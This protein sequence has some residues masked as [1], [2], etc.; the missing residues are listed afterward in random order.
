MNSSVEKNNFLGQSGFVWWMGV[1]ENRKDP[2]N[3]GRCKIRIFGWHTDDLTLIPTDDLPWAQPVLPPNNATTFTTPKEGDYVVGF[4]FDGPSGQA[5]AYFG[6]IPGVPG[7]T[8]FTG[9]DTPQKGFQDTRSSGELLT[10]PSLP[11]NVN[12]QNDGS[13]TVTNSKPASRNPETAGFSTVNKLAVNN[14]SNPPEA[15]VQRFLETTKGIT[16]PE[17]RSLTTQVAGAAQGAA[18]TLQ[19]VPPKLEALVPTAQQLAKDIQP[20]ASDAAKTAQNLLGKVQ[21]ST[22]PLL[23]T[24]QETGDSIASKL[25]S[26]GDLSGNPQS[27]IST[28]L[29]EVKAVSGKLAEQGAAAK[30]AVSAQVAEAQVEFEAAAAKAKASSAKSLDKLNSEAG[31]IADEISKKLSGLTPS[32]VNTQTPVILEVGGAGSLTGSITSFETSLYKNT[33]DEDLKYTGSDTIVWDRTNAERLRRKLPSLADIGFPRP[34]DG[35]PAATPKANLS[36]VAPAPLVNTVAP[37]PIPDQVPLDQTSSTQ[38]KSF[39]NSITLYQDLVKKETQELLA[40]LDKCVTYEQFE[41]FVAKEQVVWA[42][43]DKL[44][45][46]IEKSSNDPTVFTTLYSFT[47]KYKKQ[48]TAAVNA[49]VAAVKAGNN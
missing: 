9:S 20:A 21:T 13:G 5:P 23:Q 10:S 49:R 18:A 42:K 15:V 32:N 37:N 33:K 3:I 39:E 30:K 25:Q 6:V 48:M 2:L 17:A 8:G 4:F 28:I 19:G 22:A 44:S 1:V 12:A 7:K 31:N 16:G 14:P 36:A 11:A 27:A 35:K 38:K 43:W 24:L 40:E 26:Q 34:P 29:S 41:A 45:G 47:T 46:E